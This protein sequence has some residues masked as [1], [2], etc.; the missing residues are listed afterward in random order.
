M[1]LQVALPMRSTPSTG[2]TEPYALPRS[3][4]ETPGVAKS[5]IKVAEPR[6]ARPHVNV[7]AFSSHIQGL[8]SGGKPLNAFKDLQSKRFRVQKALC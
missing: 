4:D 5:R 6:R 8:S 2:A 7:E 3:D 1:D